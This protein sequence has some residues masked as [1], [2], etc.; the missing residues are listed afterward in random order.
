MV[1]DKI[2]L[3][4]AERVSAAVGREMQKSHSVYHGFCRQENFSH[5]PPVVA[6]GPGRAIRKHQNDFVLLGPRGSKAQ[7]QTNTK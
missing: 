2:T 3:I 1:L 6:A 7:S 5:P 4:M